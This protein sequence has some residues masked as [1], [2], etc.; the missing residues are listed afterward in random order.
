MGLQN[1]HGEL[2]D[3]Q[4]SIEK[5]ILEYFGDIFKSDNSSNFDVSL[6]VISNRVTSDM[7]E[8]LLT[9]FKA[10]KVW[11]ALQQM[12]LRKASGPNG[13]SPIFYQKFWD[14]VGLDV[15]QCV[16]DA[17][18]SGVL[19]CGLNDTYI[20]LIPKVKSPQKTTKFR[21]ISLCNVIYS[22]IS[23]VLANRLKRILKEVVHESQ[24]A[25]V[26]G[27]SI[28]DIVLIAFEMMHCIDQRR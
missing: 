5:T 27:R 19:P 1:K 14:I 17:S 10:E 23:K 12:H 15:V 28:T 25:F 11:R 2:K 26:P 18:N 22:I 9:E 4:E 16:L 13:M 21:P 8:E 6:N 24:S 7:N 3:D 20:C